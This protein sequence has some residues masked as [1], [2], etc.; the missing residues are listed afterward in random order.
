MRLP[1][2]FSAMCL[3]VSAQETATPINSIT[4]GQGASPAGV[5]V[6]SAAVK[7]SSLA[8]NDESFP[9]MVAIIVGSS[10][11][12]FGMIGVTIYFFSLE[13]PSKTNIVY[14][15]SHQGRLKTE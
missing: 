12:F 7:P 4:A 5:Y 14:K 10:L 8:I 9:F 2:I 1:I 11:V 13:D 3:A 15:L 6:G